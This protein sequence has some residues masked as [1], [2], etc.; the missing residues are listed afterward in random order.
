MSSSVSGYVGVRVPWFLC[1]TCFPMFL[2]AVNC[3]ESGSLI[4]T[5]TWF[6]S[7]FYVC[8]HPGKWLCG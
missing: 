3:E 8:M 1:D 5:C 4:A 2:Y 7:S 6:A